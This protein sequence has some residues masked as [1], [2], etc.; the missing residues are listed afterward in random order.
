MAVRPERDCLGFF[1]FLSS[2]LFS[3]GFFFDRVTLLPHHV[4]VCCFWFSHFFCYLLS[5][6]LLIFLLSSLV[7]LSFWFTFFSSCFLTL[8]DRCK[9]WEPHT[10]ARTRGYLHYKA[11]KSWHNMAMQ[12]HL[13]C[14]QQHISAC[15]CSHGNKLQH[16]RY[17]LVLPAQPFCWSLGS[18]AQ[19]LVLWGPVGLS[20]SLLGASAITSCHAAFSFRCFSCLTRMTLGIAQCS[21]REFIPLWRKHMCLG[22]ILTTIMVNCNKYNQV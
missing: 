8:I 22:C 13:L 21:F 16:L 1:S 3:L 11:Q 7:F 6:P 19:V 5:A 18:S 15:W 12:K 17:R 2:K 9:V 4:S 20:Y 10:H 14:P